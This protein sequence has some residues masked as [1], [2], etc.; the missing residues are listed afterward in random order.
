MTPP[1]RPWNWNHP[2][3]M[4]TSVIS[5]VSSM[6]ITVKVPYHIHEYHTPPVAMKGKRRLGTVSS[7]PRVV[8]GKL[9]APKLILASRDQ[10]APGYQISPPTVL[11]STSL[12]GHPQLEVHYEDDYA[13]YEL[14]PDEVF[15]SDGPPHPSHL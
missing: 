7:A 11:F 4:S 12:H 3:T 1:T 15:W 14:L 5:S 8:N 10:N 13:I 9:I 2:R 6:T